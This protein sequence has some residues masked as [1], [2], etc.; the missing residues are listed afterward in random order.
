M[1]TVIIYET[2]IDELKFIVADGDL[3][4]FNKVLVN[5]V[6]TPENLQEEF[7]DILYDPKTG[8]PTELLKSAVEDFPVEEVKNG[9]IVI[10]AG[11]IP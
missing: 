5:S 8:D 3:S 11:F 9:A 7:V 4:R 2:F 1:K 10:V 6:D